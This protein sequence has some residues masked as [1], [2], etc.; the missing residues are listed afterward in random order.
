MLNGNDTM[1]LM[2]DADVKRYAKLNAMMY[3]QTRQIQ[4]HT[5]THTNVCN[6]RS[7]QLSYPLLT[8]PAMD[9]PSL[10]C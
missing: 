9:V 5:H 1:V 3:Q 10:A 2:A 6:P 8:H 4:T 7:S